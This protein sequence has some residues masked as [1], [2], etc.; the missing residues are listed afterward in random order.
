MSR[1]SGNRFSDKDM[2]E[3]NESKA[4]RDWLE[5]GMRSG[6][7][8]ILN[9]SREGPF[10]CKIMCRPLRKFAP[11]SSWRR[12]TVPSASRECGLSEQ[13]RS[14]SPPVWSTF[15]TS[16][17]NAASGRNGRL[18]GH[19]RPWPS[20]RYL[21]LSSIGE[22]KK[23]GTC[24]S[25]IAPHLSRVGIFRPRGTTIMQQAHTKAAEHHE[26]A[27]KSHRAAAEQHGKNDHAKGQEYSSQAQQHSKTAREHSETAHS[28]SSQQ[29]KK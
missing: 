24:A 4:H 28:K 17:T 5:F 20:S 23:I 10:P 26:T 25:L 22:L 18:R 11:T 21:F 1:K 16:V 7:T 2:R 15:H 8:A 9:A 14:P 27:A 13:R 3:L 29:P 6:T 19:S 12:L